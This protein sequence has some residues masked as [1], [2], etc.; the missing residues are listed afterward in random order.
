MENK[1]LAGESFVLILPQEEAVSKSS[2]ILTT[3]GTNSDL[4]YGIIESI[5]DGLCY[6]VGDFI[7]I[8]KQSA[9][10]INYKNTKY[11]LSK[12]ENVCAYIKG[13]KAIT[14]E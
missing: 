6:N 1:L 3:G 4:V 7:Y 9:L 14:E 2:I 13:E 12:I 8:H 10:Q 11:Y 5:K